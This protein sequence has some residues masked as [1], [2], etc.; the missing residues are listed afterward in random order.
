LTAIHEPEFILFILTPR[1]ATPCTAG[2]WRDGY[3]VR[4]RLLAQAPAGFPALNGL[5]ARAA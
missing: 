1:A 2:P 3:G 4:H 5:A